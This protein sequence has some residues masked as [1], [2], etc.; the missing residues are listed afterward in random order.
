MVLFNDFPIV[1]ILNIAGISKIF[2]LH[3]VGIDVLG[4]S[5]LRGSTFVDRSGKGS[6]NYMIFTL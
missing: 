1:A 4:S 3:F 2:F 6:Y 5:F